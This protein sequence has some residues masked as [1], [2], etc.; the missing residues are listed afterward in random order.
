MLLNWL[1]TA[2]PGQGHLAYLLT[3]TFQSIVY[4]SSFLYMIIYASRDGMRHPL[5]YFLLTTRLA[6]RSQNVNSGATPSN[7]QRTISR[8]S[9]T[10]ICERTT[11][12]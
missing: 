3:L 6:D 12:F 4:V 8:G 10:W 2:T 1:V 11:N 5:E 9:I 7:S